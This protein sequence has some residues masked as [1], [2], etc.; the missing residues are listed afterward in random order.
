LVLLLHSGAVVFDI[1]IALGVTF[2]FPFVLLA[3][4][5]RT[6]PFERLRRAMENMLGGRDMLTRLFG[7]RGSLD[8]ALHDLTGR[9]ARMAWA[10]LW[11]F[12]GMFAGS[13][14]VWLVL[15]LLGHPVSPSAAIALE[16]FAL[17]IRHLAFMIPAGLGVQEVGFV[18]FGQ[19]L[20]IDSQTALAL[21]LIKRG[22]E[23]VFG[24]PILLSWQIYEAR[25][26]KR[27]AGSRSQ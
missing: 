22:R 16:S 4:L 10:T 15:K 1:L 5:G 25:H 26:M 27:W 24:L 13:F 23:I 6:R 3:V 21:S 17:A 7:R 18:M 14:E 12:L 11:Q 20:G 8:D 9:W 19:L 2:P